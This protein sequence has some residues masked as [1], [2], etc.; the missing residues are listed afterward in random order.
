MDIYD[1]AEQKRL[2]LKQVMDF[3]TSVNPLGPSSKAKHLLRKNIINIY[4]P[5]DKKLRRI[6]RLI[7]K[8]EGVRADNILFAQSPMQ[9][10]RAIFQTAKTKT[11]L[12]PS[13]VSQA[14]EEIISRN[15]VTLKRLPLDKTNHFS[16]DLENILK[17]MK[18]VDTVLMPYPHDMVGTALTIGDL[19][20]LI[21]EADRLGKTLILDE[22]YRDFTA[23]GSP[24]REVIKSETSIIV[25]TFSLFYAMA[26]LPVAYC[27]GPTDTIQ[28]MQQHIFPEEINILAVHAA[29]ASMKDIFY[30]ART[31]EFINTEKGYLLKAFT[32]MDSLEC[33]D[34]PC[35]FIVLA[36][37]EKQDTLKAF[38]SGYRILIDE[39]LDE[40]GGYYLKVP[41]KKHKWNA[42]F[43]KTL[44]N[45]LGVNTS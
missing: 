45:A 15:K 34:T 10:F 5:P 28:N 29:I 42:R 9:L 43:V 14:Y 12:I 44:R 40:Q 30:K 41:I 38:F 22:S 16:L 7:E 36:F 2:S 39:F 31:T 23:M 35:P 11:V 1:Y 8:K 32:S 37:E 20:T 13:P 25:R 6:T 19:L 27:V 4:F 33:F 21:S 3:T 17:A 18:K 24:V 26:G